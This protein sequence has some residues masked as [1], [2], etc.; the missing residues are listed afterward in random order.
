MTNYE[1]VSNLQM[2][3]VLYNFVHSEALPE[4]SFDRETF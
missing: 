3:K 2:A 4:T 1:K